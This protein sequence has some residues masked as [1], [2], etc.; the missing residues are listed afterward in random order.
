VDCTLH[1]SPWTEASPSPA[2]TTATADE[3]VVVAQ[4]AW[5]FSLCPVGVTVS[6]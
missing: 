1:G 2:M 3:V 5:S 6:S 4:N